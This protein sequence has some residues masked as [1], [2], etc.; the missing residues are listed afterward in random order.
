MQNIQKLDEYIDYENNHGLLKVNPFS[1]FKSEIYFNPEKLNE[2]K[3]YNKI[4]NIDI[5]KLVSTENIYDNIT[6]TF[7][8]KTFNEFC[9]IFNNLKKKKSGFEFFI[10]L[11]TGSKKPT[12]EFQSLLK[13]SCI[14]S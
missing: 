14:N 3:R 10:I 13:F 11:L 12:N 4:Y 1:I 9:K 5:H 6:I 2:I 7:D 8:S